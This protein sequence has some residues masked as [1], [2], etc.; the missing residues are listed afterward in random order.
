MR[1]FVLPSRAAPHAPHSVRSAAFSERQ[2]EQFH[3]SFVWTALAQIDPAFGLTAATTLKFKL[4]LARTSDQI[5][6]AGQHPLEHRH[7]VC[8]SACGAAGRREQTEKG[9]GGSAGEPTLL[10]TS[11]T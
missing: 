6:G 9:G 2:A 7:K 3:A 5:A 4:K 10:T 11:D 1:T 8:Q